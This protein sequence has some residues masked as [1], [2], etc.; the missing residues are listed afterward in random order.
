MIYTNI[1][2]KVVARQMSFGE[3]AGVAIGEFGRGR[4]EV[5]LPTPAGVESFKGLCLDLTIGT[6]KTGRPRINKAKDNELYLI[7]SSGRSYTR[8]GDGII[9]TLKDAQV[10]LVAKANGADGAAGR[11]GTWDAVIVKAHDGDVFRVTWGGNGYGYEPTYYVVSQGKVFEAE[12]HEVEDL[13]EK[14][15]L[16][17]PFTLRYDEDGDLIIDSSDWRIVR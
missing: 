13:Y 16:E 17:M 5:F 4:R 9:R 12:Q 14:L 11:I 8:R 15:G 3:V 10:E 2:L 7:L 1:E 6:S